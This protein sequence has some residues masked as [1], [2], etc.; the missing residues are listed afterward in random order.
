M[1][2]KA[3]PAS[4]RRQSKLFDDEGTALLDFID[5][6]HP[7]VRM[8]D[9]MQWELF[10]SH[11]SALHSGAGG[12]MASS[13]RQVAGLLMLKHM[14]ALSDERLME[15]WVTNP[16]FQYFCGETH[17]QHRPPVDPT[18][19]TKWRNRFGGR[20]HGVAADDSGRERD[21]QRRGGAQ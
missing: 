20:R 18:S 15:L 3:D 12:R 14:E 19:M 8:A 6:K 2:P 7:L 4:K 17:F 9:S 16:Y 1:K 13:G 11:W 21:T 10:E 5:R